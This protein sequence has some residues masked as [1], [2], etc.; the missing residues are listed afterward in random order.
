[1]EENCLGHFKVI[2]DTIVALVTV[3]SLIVIWLT[4]REMR[5]QRHKAFEPHLI[6]LNFE[7]IF[8]TRYPEI[9]LP[10]K[11]YLSR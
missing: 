8:W 2:I 4:L 7:I 6:P 1:M 11:F 10:I 3:F 5:I 9:L